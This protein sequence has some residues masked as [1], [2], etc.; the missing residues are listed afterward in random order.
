VKFCILLIAMLLWNLNTKIVDLET[1]YLHG[2]LKEEIFMEIS[3]G[4]D[5]TNEECLS[6]NMTIN[7]Q[8]QSSR[9]FY[10]K[11]LEGLKNFGLKVSEVDLCL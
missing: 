1:A 4:M 10:I 7:D 3:E 8:F 6:L 9:Q 2:Y 11:L 5:A